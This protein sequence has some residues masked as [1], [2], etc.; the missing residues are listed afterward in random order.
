M[1][2]EEAV[3]TNVVMLRG[4]DELSTGDIFEYLRRYPPR[5]LEWIDDTSC[6]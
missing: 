6:K 4:V 2:G 3:R 5:K 1:E